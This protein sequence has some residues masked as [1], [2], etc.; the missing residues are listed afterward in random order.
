MCVIMICYSFQDTY[1][2]AWK[3]NYEHLICFSSLAFKWRTFNSSSFWATDSYSGCQDRPWTNSGHWK[4][5]G[6]VFGQIKWN[7]LT[8]IWIL[9]GG[10]AGAGEVGLPL[11]PP[12]R[13]KLLHR[14]FHINYGKSARSP[15]SGRFDVVNT[16]I[17]DIESNSG[18]GNRLQNAKP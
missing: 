14:I 12:L 1:R 17:V 18:I 10:R 11:Y 5:T 3:G 16:N 7:I 15:A 9:K 2:V 6:H 8:Q 4:A 13:S